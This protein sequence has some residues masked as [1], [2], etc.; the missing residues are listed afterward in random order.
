MVFAQSKTVCLGQKQQSHPTK[1]IRWNSRRQENIS[2]ALC[3]SCLEQG[4]APGMEA[5]NHVQ[6][7]VTWL[8]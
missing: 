6:S 7:K 4:A 3:Q 2:T 5:K 1:E 8:R